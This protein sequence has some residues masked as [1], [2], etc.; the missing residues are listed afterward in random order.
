MT[1]GLRDGRKTINPDLARER[2]N[3]S[4]DPLELTNILDGSVQKTKERRDLGK[5]NYNKFIH[6]SPLGRLLNAVNTSDNLLFA[7]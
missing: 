3:C 7:W 4:F 5:L 1:K 6:W 2:Q